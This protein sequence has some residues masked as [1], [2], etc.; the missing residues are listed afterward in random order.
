MTGDAV[1]HDVG[2]R[3]TRRDPVVAGLAQHDPGDRR[4][5]AVDP[6]DRPESEAAAGRAVRAGLDADKAVVPEQGVGVVH[7]AGSRPCPPESLWTDRTSGQF[8]TRIWLLCRESACSASVQD[9]RT[10]EASRDVD[11]R[12]PRTRPE[13][14][15]SNVL[16][17]SDSRNTQTG[18]VAAREPIR[19]DTSD[20]AP[21]C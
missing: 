4:P 1:D 19:A 7:G 11:A 16:A 6:A 8:G 9:L 2:G 10:T 15:D 3:E 18:A 17:D 14:L 20:G 21:R 5:L 13:H 12:R